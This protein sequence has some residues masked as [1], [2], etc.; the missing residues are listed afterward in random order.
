MLEKIKKYFDRKIEA[1]QMLEK[2]P[3]NLGTALL[4]PGAAAPQISLPAQVVEVDAIDW[5][6]EARQ[7][8]PM[9]TPE[10]I[11][12]LLRFENAEQTAARIKNDYLRYANERAGRLQHR[13]EAKMATR[14]VS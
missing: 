6:E 9:R 4:R 11:W 12:F 10:R 8:L 7:D 13:T 5:N 3:L 2:P 1:T 14:R